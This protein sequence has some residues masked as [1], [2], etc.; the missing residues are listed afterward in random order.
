MF[1]NTGVSLNV[2]E[3]FKLVLEYLKKPKSIKKTC[4]E[5]DI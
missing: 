1:F 2:N 5:T 3:N 4:Y